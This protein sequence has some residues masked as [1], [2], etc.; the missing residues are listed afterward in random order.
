MRPLKM[1]TMAIPGIVN[2]Q[3]ASNQ[4]ELPGAGASPFLIGVILKKTE[5]INDLAATAEISNAQAKLVIERIVAIIQTG[6][7]KEGRF[8]LSGIGTFTVR[9]RAARMGRNPSTNQPL[10]IKA[11]TGVGF[12]ASPDLK[13]AAAKAKVAAKA[14]VAS[15]TPVAAKKVAAKSGTK[16]KV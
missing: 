6:L 9:K 11:S 5:M 7:K 12:K 16:A 2:M 1:A 13:A 15:K 10:K 3:A 8:P 14:P 4:T